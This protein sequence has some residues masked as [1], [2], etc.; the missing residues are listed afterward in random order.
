M[1]LS[2]LHS[3]PTGLPVIVQDFSDA[4]PSDPIVLGFNDEM[5]CLSG[6]FLFT[7]GSN[8]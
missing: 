3:V 6:V 5:Y 1:F 2:G 8:G 4:L 7:Y